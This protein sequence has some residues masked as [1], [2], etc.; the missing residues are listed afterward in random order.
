MGLRN[1]LATA[2]MALALGAAGSAAAADYAYMTGTGNP[3]G[4]DTNEQAMDGAFGVG[5]WDKFNG[6]DAN[7]F[8]AGYAFI[9]F[10]GSDGE[11]GQFDLF[12]F[13]NAGAIET[14]VGAG[15][16]V[17]VNVARNSSYGT[18]DIGFGASITGLSDYSI[19]SNNAVVTA[20]GILAGLDGNGAG[21]NFTGGYFSHDVVAGTDVCYVSGDFG[22]VFGAVTEGL[23]VGGQTTTNFHSGDNPLQL[24]VNEL[25]FAATG[26]VNVGVVPEPATWALMIGGFGLAGAALRR[27]KAAFA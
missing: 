26:A 18:S 21:T 4:S 1:Y 27:R 5:A 6:F 12:L 7:V 14:F 20:A 11:T 24:R 3:W 23:F 9:Y 19:A 25:Q 2:T 10:D 17:F 15:G 13:N 22:C 16:R 8:T